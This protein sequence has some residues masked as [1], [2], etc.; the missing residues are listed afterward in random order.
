VFKGDKYWMM[1][2]DSVAPGY[3]RKISDSWPGLPSNIDAALTWKS[4]GYTFFFKGYQ[5]WRFTDRSPSPGYPKDISNWQGL[6]ANLDAAI[7]WGKDGDLYFFAGSQYWKYDTDLQKMARGYP[8]DMS[9]AWQD[10]PGNV[11]AALQWSNGKTYF[12]KSGKYWRF[13]DDTGAVDRNNPSF[14]RDAGLWWFGC[15][16][17]KRLTIPFT[18]G[19]V[20]IDTEH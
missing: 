12:F 16:Q 14:P 1:T 6:P 5:Y 18:D 19:T 2:D 7:E 3:P 15:P 20:E 17:K 9:A 4:T 13:N 10:V 11:D 8:R